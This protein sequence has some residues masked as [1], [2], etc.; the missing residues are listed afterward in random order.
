MRSAARPF[1][2][3]TVYALA[4]HWLA[5]YEPV[6]GHGRSHEDVTWD[7]AGEIQA[8]IEDFLSRAEDQDQLRARR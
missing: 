4:Q 6:P 8:A 1:V 7:L 2:D 3:S 5:S